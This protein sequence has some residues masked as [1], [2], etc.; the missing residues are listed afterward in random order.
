MDILQHSALVWKELTEYKYLLTYGYKQ[1]LHTI[2]LTFSFED[3]PHLAG[4]QYLKDI[5]LPNFTSA[6]IADRILEGK[7]SFEQIKKSQQYEDMV[8]PRL[9]ALTHLKNSL[10]NDFKLHSFNPLIYPFKTTIKADY[11]IVSNNSVNSFIFIIQADTDDTAKCDFLCCS[12]FKQGTRDYTTNQKSYILLRKERLHVS[13]N[14]STLF[15]SK[16]KPLPSSNN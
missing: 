3:Y 1:K 14:T 11:L 10:D 16:I 12:A 13:S 9:E 4:F 6:K 2:N 8:K 15:F 7:I 5:S